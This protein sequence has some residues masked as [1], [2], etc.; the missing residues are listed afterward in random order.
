MLKERIEEMKKG[1]ELQRLSKEEQVKREVQDNHEYMKRVMDHA[2]REKKRQ[3][4]KD[5]RHKETIRDNQSFVKTQIDDKLRSPEFKK[6]LVYNNGTGV[7][8]EIMNESEI[9]YNRDIFAKLEGMRVTKRT[10]QS[11]ATKKSAL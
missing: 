3:E 5:K 7:G 1:I 6:S 11:N 8:P 2:E 9:R 4:D 10:E